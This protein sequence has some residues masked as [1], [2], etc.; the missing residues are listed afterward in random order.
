MLQHHLKIEI[1]FFDLFDKNRFSTI[2]LR[3]VHGVFYFFIKIQG[4]IFNLKLFPQYYQCGSRQGEGTLPSFNTSETGGKICRRCRW[5]WW[6]TLT[7]KYLREFSKKI[8]TV[9]MEYSGAE[10]KLI[11][12]KTSSKKSFDTVPLRR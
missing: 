1:V 2:F 4:D 11:Y 3:N 12:E 9:L 7:C 8:E 5:H 6:C 10:G